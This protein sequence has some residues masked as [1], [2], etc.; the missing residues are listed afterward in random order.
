M[1][2]IISIPLLIS[3]QNLKNY[4]DLNIANFN[5]L[6]KEHKYNRRDFNNK[7]QTI[8]N[9]QQIDINI[10]KLE[11][12]SQEINNGLH[13]V[14]DI[15]KDNS[16]EITNYKNDKRLSIRNSLIT[17]RNNEFWGNIYTIMKK[18]LILLTIILIGY[19]LYSS[20]YNKTIT[21]TPTIVVLMIFV[22]M[23]IVFTII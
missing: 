12:K 22:I 3:P 10:P 9:E 6:E 17:M 2:G 11:K 23:L 14:H 18:V 1:G 13:I 21:K 15:Y 19:Y 4:Q 5:I 20:V 16:E 7:F 8:N